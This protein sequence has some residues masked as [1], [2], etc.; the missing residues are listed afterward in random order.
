MNEGV[1][2]RSSSSESGTIRVKSGAWQKDLPA[3]MTVKEAREHLSMYTN[4]PEGAKAYSGNTVLND[5]D[6]IEAGMSVEYSKKSG[7]KG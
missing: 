4:I 5:D 3:G 7:E 1:S 2:S 6:I